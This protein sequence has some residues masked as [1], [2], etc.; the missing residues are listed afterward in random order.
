[1]S[2]FSADWLAGTI[3]GVVAFYIGILALA[4]MAGRVLPYCC[5]DSVSFGVSMLPLIL[6]FALISTVPYMLEKGR[7]WAKEE[8][9]RG[10]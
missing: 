8:V 3:W 10:E 1:M 5:G 4:H 7:G 6:A 2:D 9:Y